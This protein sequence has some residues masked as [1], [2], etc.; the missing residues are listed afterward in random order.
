[1]TAA[2]LWI[3]LPILFGGIAFIFRSGRTIYRWGTLIALGLAILALLLPFD[4]PFRLAGLHIKVTSNFQFLGR[5]LVFDRQIVYVLVVLYG[6]TAMWFYGLRA[7]PQVRE[8]VPWGL[9]F[10]GLLVA[11]LTVRP[12]LYAAILLE[13]LG[14]LLL[15]LVKPLAKSALRFLAHQS[16]ALPLLMVAAFLSGS[17]GNFIADPQRGPIVLALLG[18]GLALSVGIF[19]FHSWMPLMGEELHPYLSTFLLWLLPF[20]TLLFLAGF[21]GRFPSLND[22]TISSALQLSG[23]FMALVGS[24]GIATGRHWGRAFGYAVMIE[25]GYGLLALSL[26]KSGQSLMVTSLLPRSITFIIWGF[27]LSILYH[28]A[29]KLEHPSLE[30]IG[31]RLPV[32]SIALLLAIFSLAGFPL[33]AAFPWRLSLWE[34]LTELSPVLG[35]LFLLSLL[36]IFG[37]GLRTFNVLFVHRQSTWHQEETLTELILL[38]LGMMGIITL[39]LFPQM[40]ML[41][42]R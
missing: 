2:H 15:F 16:L 17:E 37:H 30:G 24:G 35:F 23:T 42:A 14:F 5:S 6:I 9:V 22:T 34:R 41:I 39:G 40:I 29:G 8:I 31:H 26:G 25:T 27:A 32:A 3:F 36:G 12:F 20:S 4:T 38:T 21:V 7:M 28:H 19:P 11:L 13:A 1:M 33:L 18:M 10:N